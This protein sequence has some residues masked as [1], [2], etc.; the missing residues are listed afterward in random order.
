MFLALWQVVIIQGGSTYKFST[1]HGKSWGNK[2]V[3]AFGAN[4][5]FVYGEK[6]IVHSK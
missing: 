3:F 1:A 4:G 2:K 6:V 5:T